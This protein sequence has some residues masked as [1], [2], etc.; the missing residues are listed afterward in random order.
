MK[1]EVGRREHRRYVFSGKYRNVMLPESC[2]Q[3]PI[4]EVTEIL[5]EAVVIESGG[6][7]EKARALSS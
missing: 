4:D 6:S 3:D 2:P 1:L 7:L 5:G